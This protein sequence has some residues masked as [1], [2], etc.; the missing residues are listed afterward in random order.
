[1]H[2]WHCNLPHE[3]GVFTII[4]NTIQIAVGTGPISEITTVEDTIEIAI[5]C[6]SLLSDKNPEP[7]PD[8]SPKGIN[9]VNIHQA[10]RSNRN[11]W[12]SPK[13]TRNHQEDHPDRN[14]WLFLD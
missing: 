7:H 11:R 2:R 6:R 8:R 12:L 10:H 14:H 3:I 5:L 4:G 1:M 13:P 9:C